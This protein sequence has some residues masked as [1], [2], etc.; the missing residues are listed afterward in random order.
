MIIDYMNATPSG[1]PVCSELTLSSVCKIFSHGGGEDDDDDHDCE[2][3]D[4]EED[5]LS[6]WCILDT[7]ADKKGG[8]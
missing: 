7:G 2:D 4:E 3:D 6:T 5:D 8:S 1:H